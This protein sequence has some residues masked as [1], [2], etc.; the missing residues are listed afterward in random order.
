MLMLA[1]VHGQPSPPT[2]HAPPRLDLRDIKVVEKV[3][4]TVDDSEMIDG[5]VFDQKAAKAAGGPTKMEKAKIALIQKYLDRPL[6]VTLR[7][8]V[9]YTL[10]ELPSSTQTTK[11]A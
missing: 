3:G 7:L 9:E 2:I 10:P 5:I 6:H 11:K 8:A 1:A 4:G